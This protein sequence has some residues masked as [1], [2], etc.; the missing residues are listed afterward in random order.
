MLLIEVEFS[1]NEVSVYKHILDSIWK[2]RPP[3]HLPCGHLSYI[4]CNYS[5]EK[6]LNYL[7]VSRG[8]MRHYTIG[9]HSFRI[10]PVPCSLFIR[11]YIPLQLARENKNIST[12]KFHHRTT[13]MHHKLVPDPPKKHPAQTQHRTTKCQKP[14]RGRQWP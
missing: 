12:N 8:M 4:H 5:I 14:Q 11:A 7:N 2:F 3:A 10:N 9:K 1:Q 6:P 13:Y